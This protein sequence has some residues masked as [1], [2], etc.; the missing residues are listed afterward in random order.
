MN[1]ETW[2]RL[3]SHFADVERAAGPVT[4]AANLPD[5]EEISEAESKLG[6]KFC[7][8]YAEFV[9]RYGGAIVGAFPVFGL[10]PVLAMGNPWSVVAVTLQFREQVW[11]GTADWYVVSE[12]GFGNPIGIA[13]DG[14]VMISDHDAGE[15]A[16]LEANFEAF[17]LQHCLTAGTR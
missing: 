3:E 17:L 12:D 10:R 7:K 15:I 13:A 4:R 8:D 6:L 9:L 5:A 1:N 14:A 16:P 11:P 2:T